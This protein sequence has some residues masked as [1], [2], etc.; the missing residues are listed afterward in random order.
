MSLRARKELVTE[1]LYLY[2]AEDPVPLTAHSVL[3]LLADDPPPMVRLGGTN[4]DRAFDEAR[5]LVH[6]YAN[7]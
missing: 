2:P 5:V 1:D 3:F 4:L 7:S 6:R